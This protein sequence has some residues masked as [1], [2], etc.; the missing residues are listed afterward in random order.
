VASILNSAFGNH[1]VAE[2]HQFFNVALE[3]IRVSANVTYPFTVTFQELSL[4]GLARHRL[5]QLEFDVAHWRRHTPDA[6][7]GSEVAIDAPLQC[8]PRGTF[9]KWAY[10]EAFV[11]GLGRVYVADHHADLVC[12]IPGVRS[13]ALFTRHGFSSSAKR[14]SPGIRQYSL[15]PYQ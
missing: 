10:A 6:R 11:E 7:I 8:V 5:Q 9:D 12:P 2:T 3:V 1:L 13:S 4:D 15:V 14:V